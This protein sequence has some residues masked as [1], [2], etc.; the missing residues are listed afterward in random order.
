MSRKPSEKLLRM[1]SNSLICIS[2]DDNDNAFSIIEQT[3][4]SFSFSFIR[5]RYQ[6][7]KKNRTS[8]LNLQKTVYL[9]RDTPFLYH[10]RFCFTQEPKGILLVRRS[11]F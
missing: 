9:I 11:L 5:Q 4:I 1:P 10:K 8:N 3:S 2:T 6:K 7:I